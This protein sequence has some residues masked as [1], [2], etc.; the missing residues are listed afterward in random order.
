[1]GEHGLS[2]SPMGRKRNR[3]RYL[4]LR[5]K[6]ESKVNNLAIVRADPSVAI[7]L[8]KY[9]LF[10]LMGNF[11]WN[12]E[13]G[14]VTPC[15]GAGGSADGSTSGS[16]YARRPVSRVLSAPFGLLLF[17]GPPGDTGRPFLWDAPRSAPHATNPGDEAGMPLRPWDKVGPRPTPPAAP[18]RSC[19]RWGLPCRSCCQ[20][21]GALL[22]HRFTLARAPSGKVPPG[23]PCQ[24]TLAGEA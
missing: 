11:V 16:K 21:R 23:D 12:P 13:D 7:L 10:V 3:G 4:V 1:M 15:W 24:V 17:R 22:P 14:I 2:C 20:E 9:S 18:I 8:V 5:G 19:S 6:F